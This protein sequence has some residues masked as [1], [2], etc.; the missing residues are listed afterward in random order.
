[1]RA[2]VLLLV[3]AIFPAMAARAADYFVYIG[4][5]TRTHG[6]GIYTFRFDPVTGKTTPPTLAAESSSPSFLAVHPNRRF[7]Y[8]ENEH[9][10]EDVDGKNDTISAFA[11]NQKTGALTFLNKVSSRGEGPAQIAV[12]KTGRQLLAGNYRS[13]S[14]A[15]FPIRPDGRLGEATGFDQEHGSGPK[16]KQDRPRAHGVAFSPDGRFALVAENGTDQVMIYRIDAAKGTLTPNNP[17]FFKAP[18]G[19]GPRHVAFHPNGDIVYALNELESAITV[20]AWGASNGTL[21]QVQEVATLPP[22]FKGTSAPAQL[23]LDRAGRFLYASNRG[24]DTIAVLSIDPAKSTLTPV[25]FVPTGGKTPRDFNLDPTGGYLF[26]GNQT[27]DNVAIFRIDP[28]TGRLTPFG[29]PIENVPEPAC[30]VF[31]AHQ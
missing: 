27:S 8:A 13:G 16:P 19:Y 1:M 30:V 15:L 26:V 12:D 25:E 23:Q 2:F 29:K 28:K 20:L 9:N 22:D 24:A 17:A 31:V 4:T 3:T 14:V 5:Y 21:T 11:I 10:G 6:K 7:L 18:A